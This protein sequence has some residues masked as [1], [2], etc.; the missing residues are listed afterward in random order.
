[1]TEEV[2]PLLV[3][4]KERKGGIFQELQ[5]REDR[6]KGRRWEAELGCIREVFA[7]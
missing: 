3:E 5:Q 2:Q 1:M 7:R 4:D 6:R